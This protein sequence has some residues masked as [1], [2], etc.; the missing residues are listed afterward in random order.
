MSWIDFYLIG[1]LVAFLLMLL[2]YATR[3]GLRDAAFGDGTFKLI[4]FSVPLLS[5]GYVA[6]KMFDWILKLIDRLVDGKDNSRN[7]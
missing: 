5:W 2:D 3:K 6:I 7:D 4:M 1:V